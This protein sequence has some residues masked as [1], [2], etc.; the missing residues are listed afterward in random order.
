MLLGLP[1]SSR[2]VMAEGLKSPQAGKV[3]QPLRVPSVTRWTNVT[4]RTL[5]SSAEPCGMLMVIQ[6]EGAVV[7][8]KNVAELE[9]RCTAFL[10]PGKGSHHLLSEGGIV[11]EEQFH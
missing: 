2:K 9:E 7:V 10:V 1:L 11:M 3:V 4:V 8:S 6:R 5:K